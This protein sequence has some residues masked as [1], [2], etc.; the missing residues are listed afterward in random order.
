MNRFTA[1][2]RE[3][4]LGWETPLYLERRRFSS[5]FRED[6][7]MQ[8]YTDLKVWQ[9]SHALVLSI[10]RLSDRFPASKR[11]GLTS[12]LRRA[13]VSVPSNIAEGSKRRSPQHFAHHLN[14]AEGSLAEAD[15][16][17]LLSRDLGYA[18]ESAVQPLRA[19][20]DEI[21]RMLF[22]LRTKVEQ[23]E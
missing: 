7:L 19:E 9:R 5:D 18:T 11:F 23:G 6:G 1:P 13:A 22:Q 14:V 3:G 17:L 12:Q 4:G 20:A 8:R 15:Y 16:Q 10:Y 21:A 2:L